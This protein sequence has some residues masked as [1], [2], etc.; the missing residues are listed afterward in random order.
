MLLYCWLIYLARE[1]SLAHLYCL[2]R[3]VRADQRTGGASRDYRG[4]LEARFLP[5]RCRRR[6]HTERGAH[7]FESARQW[8][9][10]PEASG[11]GLCAPRHSPEDKKRPVPRG[12]WP[13]YGSRNCHRSRGPRYG[14]STACSSRAGLRYHLQTS[15]RYLSFHRSPL[16][17]YWYCKLP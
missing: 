3:P 11:N 14:R 12:R 8:P 1:R 15:Q 7:V 10:C 13:P 16:T 9:P 17:L 6:T 5:S 4:S 2:P